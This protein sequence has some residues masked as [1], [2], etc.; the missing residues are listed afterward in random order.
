[1]ATLLNKAVSWARGEV[2]KA[3]R[4][5]LTDYVPNAPHQYGQPWPA[6]ADVDVQA[7]ITPQ[8]MREIVSKVGTPAACLNAV[9]DYASNVKIDLRSVDPA[10]KADPATVA[11]IE[12][13]L[14]RP[15]KN[16]D[17]LEF[18]KLLIQDLFT[19]GMAAIEIE[20]GPSG[21]FANLNVLDMSRLFID[22]DQHGTPLGFDMLNIYG[23]P[24]SRDA[25]SPYAWLPDEVIFMRRDPRSDTLYSRSRV[26]QLFVYAV[27]ED[28][29][30]SY[31]AQRF[32][33]SNVPRGVF[34]L[35]DITEN[36]LRKA[37]DMWNNQYESA[38]R[39]MLTGSKG[40]SNWYP[41]NYNLSEL[42]AKDLLD[43]VQ[44]K[45]MG[46][47]GVTKNELGDSQDISKSNGYNLSYTFKKRAIEPILNTICEK[48]TT[49]FLWDTLGETSLEHYYHEIDSR[50]E[51]IQA[52]IDKETTEHGVTTINQVRNRRG[53]PSVPGG[54]E[55][56]VLVGG[57][58]IPVSLAKQFAKA[59]LDAIV[60]ETEILKL[61]VQ[62]SRLQMAMMA[63]STQ[64]GAG[65]GALAGAGAQPPPKSNVMPP[66]IRPMGPAEK[67]TT[68][69]GQGSSS[70]KMKLP[71]PQAPSTAQ[72]DIGQKPRGTIQTLRNAGVR[73]TKETTE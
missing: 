10:Q 29:I 61:Q 70:F 31:I 12:S 8:R 50:D 38:H 67:F 39:I 65:A 54:D 45:I 26:S 57:S 3:S 30:A 68:P 66:I 33:D 13:F 58:L 55:P 71:K 6:T 16:F 64:A 11:A 51:L 37:V 48:L 34:D 49:R 36:E 40:K 69:D 4:G 23:W 63:Q 46:I 47:V 52:Q 18:K 22:F 5:T 27:I 72:A 44:A 41:F 43:A 32:T 25:N 15:N 59:Q 1:M 53:D 62:Q 28:L 56:M 7:L 60:A 14:R 20:R 21:K 17:G 19:F 42:Q 35:G 24:I 2:V 9:L 73:P